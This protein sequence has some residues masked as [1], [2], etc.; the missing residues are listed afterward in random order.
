MP[1]WASSCLPAMEEYDLSRNHITG[2]IP[3]DVGNQTRMNQFKFQG[4]GCK[5]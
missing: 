5:Q 1:P 3:A 4:E 2:T